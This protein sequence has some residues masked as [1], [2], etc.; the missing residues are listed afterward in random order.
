MA[1]K[2]DTRILVTQ[3][4]LPALEEVNTYLEDIWSSKWLT[5]R[6]KYHQELEK[7]LA[8]FLEV[9]YISLFANG[10]LALFTALQALKVTNEVVTTPY[11]FVATTHALWWNNI[12]P[13]FADVDPQTC[14]LSPEAV[15]A[16]ITQKTTALL[17]VHVYGNPAENE[18]LQELADIYGLYMIYDAAHA[19]GVRKGGQSVMEWGDLSILSFHATKVY[20]T[21]EGGAIVCHNSRTK[22]R[23]DYLKNFGFAGETRV[24]APGINA[25][26][27]EFQATIGLLQLKYFD[28]IVNRRKAIAAHYA[29]NLKDVPGVRIFEVPADTQWNYAYFPIFINAK[30][31]GHTRDELYDHLKT[32]NYYGRRYFYP[33]ISNFRMYKNLPSAGASNLPHA[34]QVADS[35]LCLPIYPELEFR[36]VDNVSEIIA[37][38]AKGH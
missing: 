14:N 19:F 32:Y 24:M 12:Q 9:P 7:Q 18:Q 38:F 22:R 28:E 17:P 16:A 8:E 5:N 1:F 35:V 11:S 2:S 20:N 26:M 36:H 6:G 34:E 10:T 21:F 27:N 37:Q 23:I 4:F 30:A 25:K 33:L 13:V 29:E 3:P 31:Y 15:E